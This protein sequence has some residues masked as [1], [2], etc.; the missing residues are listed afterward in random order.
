MGAWRLDVAPEDPGSD[1]VYLHVLYP[2]DTKT[3][4]VPPCSVKRD[5]K[6]LAVKVGELAYT[7]NP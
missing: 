1:C 2:T 4:A 6:K 5:G 7:F 3:K